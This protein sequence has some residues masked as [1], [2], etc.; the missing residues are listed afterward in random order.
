MTPLKHSNWNDSFKT[1]KLNWLLQNTQIEMTSSKHSDLND[2]K[3][4]MIPTK[5]FNQRI[6]SKHFNP[7]GSLHYLNPNNFNQNR[8]FPPNTS[9]QT[10]PSKH[11]NPND[12]LQTVQSKWFPPNTSIQKIPSKRF[13]QN[14][15]IKMIIPNAPIKMIIPNASIQMIHS[16][17]FYSKDSILLVLLNPTLYDLIFVSKKRQYTHHHSY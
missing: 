4:E 2:L 6:P 14:T 8:Q 9:I 1:L 10:I 16:K 5:H 3:T 15:S 13:P 12:S 17:L 11:F 7:R